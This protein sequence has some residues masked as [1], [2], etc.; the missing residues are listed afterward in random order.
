MC[1]CGQIGVR[2]GVRKRNQVEFKKNAVENQTQWRASKDVVAITQTHLS[3]EY[4]E[5]QNRVTY[6]NQ[7]GKLCEKQWPN[8]T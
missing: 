2:S 6:A 7:N 5:K 3:R 1:I 8:G 4:I